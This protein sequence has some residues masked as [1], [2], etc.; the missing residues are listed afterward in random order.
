MGG[1]GLEE[2]CCTSLRTA[3]EFARPCRKEM[4]SSGQRVKQEEERMVKREVVKSERSNKYVE[5]DMGGGCWF[6]EMRVGSSQFPQLSSSSF[7]ICLA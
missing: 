7:P 2:F 6:V 1:V 3:V 4:F 5:G